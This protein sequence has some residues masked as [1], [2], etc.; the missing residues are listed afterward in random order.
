MRF[1]G[2]FGRKS[3]GYGVGPRTWQ[4]WLV[5]ALLLGGMFAGRRWFDPQQFGLA[6]WTRTALPITLG[7]VFLLVMWL[8][9]DD[10]A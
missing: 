9:Y 7:A 2:W 3:V 6:P 1:K 4:G 8:T 10:E 5:T